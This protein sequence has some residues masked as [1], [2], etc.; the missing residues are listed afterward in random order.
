MPSRLEVIVD[1]DGVLFESISFVSSCMEG[2]E[3]PKSLLW[4]SVD[5]AET[6]PDDVDDDDSKVGEATFDGF[7]GGYN[8]L[9]IKR[10]EPLGLPLIPYCNSLAEIC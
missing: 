1:E 2:T 7:I 4:M 5:D 10:G 6:V 9:G 3:P 8:V